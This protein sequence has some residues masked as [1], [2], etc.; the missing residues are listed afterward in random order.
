MKHFIILISFV[1]SLMAS[2]Q[3]S[4]EE[5]MKA[6]LDSLQNIT[7]PDGFVRCA[8]HFERI[9]MM[10]S[11]EWLP[12][13]YSAYCKVILAFQKEDVTEKEKLLQKA[14]LQIDAALKLNPDE[15]ELYVLQGLF[16]QAYIGLD[17]VNNGQ[18]YSQKANGSFEQGMRLDDTNPRP[19]YLHAVNIMYTPEQFGGGMKSACPL[20]L[21]SKELFNSYEIKNDLYPDWGK[22]DCE[23]YCKE[24][25]K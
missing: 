14:E 4:Y 9:A 11:G 3:G 23:N 1:Y 21:K 13:Y 2:G 24:C 22:E 20:F 18:V 6:G 12:L 19:Y 16:Y 15:A 17:P 7:S 5:A 25:I 10:E 8:N